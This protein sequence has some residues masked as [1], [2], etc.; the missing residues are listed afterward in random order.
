[1]ALRYLPIA[2]MRWQSSLGNMLAAGTVVIRTGCGCG[3]WGEVNLEHMI[4]VLGG[5]QMTLWD[6]RPPCPLCGRLQHFMASPGR[7][8]PKRLLLSVPHD[9]EE[10][11]LPP[12]AWMAGWTGRRLR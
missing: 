2:V 8:T 1:V 6:C 12:Q 11:P 4:A 10:H 3:V 9:A 7:G 5:P